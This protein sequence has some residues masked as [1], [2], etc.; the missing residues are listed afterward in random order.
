MKFTELLS[1]M[2][3]L[4]QSFWWL[5]FHIYYINKCFLQYDF[6]YLIVLKPLTRVQIESSGRRKFHIDY[7]LFQYTFFDAQ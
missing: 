3:S 5:I 1:K 4:M 6:W 7:I 2:I